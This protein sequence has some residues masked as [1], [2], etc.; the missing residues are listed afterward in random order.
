MRERLGVAYFLNDEFLGR[1]R[2]AQFASNRKS[3]VVLVLEHSMSFLTFLPSSSPTVNVST[4]AAVATASLVF[5]LLSWPLCVVVS[6]AR[7][8]E[9]KL[10]PRLA[11]GWP[12]V[13]PRLASMRTTAKAMNLHICMTQRQ[14]GGQQMMV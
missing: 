2:N 7:M 6:L 10:V 13:G 8:A 11:Q 1:A 4:A 9:A 5:L 12:E 3:A 14:G